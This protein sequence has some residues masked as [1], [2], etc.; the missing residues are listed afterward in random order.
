VSVN[1]D[2]IAELRGQMAAAG[3]DCVVMYPSAIGLPN[4]DAE[5]MTAAAPGALVCGWSDLEG[6]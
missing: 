2:R 4:F 3:L 5:E 1:P 6:P